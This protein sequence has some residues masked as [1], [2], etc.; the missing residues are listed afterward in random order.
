M[1]NQK[2]KS[3][4]FNPYKKQSH[5]V[6]HLITVFLLVI[7]AFAGGLYFAGV[8]IFSPFGGGVG[9][10][11]N[12]LSQGGKIGDS[13]LGKKV[14][15]GSYEEG[16]QAALEFARKR[17]AEEDLFITEVELNRLRATVKSV[18]G[19]NVVVEFEASVLDVF[20]EGMATKT[21]M[22]SGEN[23]IEKR[24][25]KL[26]RNQEIKTLYLIHSF[27]TNGEIKC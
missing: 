27:Q 13:V 16:Y 19:N 9:E 11:S 7:L 20:R 10:S 1:A 5:F 2:L 25:Q 3:Y 14:K 8:G 18:S 6:R 21:V 26:K 23:V 22:V 12:L 4:P 24:I 17:L 15:K